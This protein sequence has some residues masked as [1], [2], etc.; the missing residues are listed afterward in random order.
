MGAAVSYFPDSLKMRAR[1]C[2]ETYRP[3][4][5]NKGTLNYS[6]SLIHN[7]KVHFKVLDVAG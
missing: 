2:I 1:L 5:V 7:G 6:K 4:A 3:L